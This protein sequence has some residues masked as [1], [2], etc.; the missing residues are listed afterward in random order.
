MWEIGSGSEVAPR[1]DLAGLKKWK[2]KVGKAM[3]ALRITV[4]E[5]LLEHI[6]YA[7]TPK[8]AWDTFAALFSKKSNARLQLLENK[9][10]SVEQKEMK[11]NQYFNKVKSLCQ[12]ILELDPTTSISESTMR[13]II[14]HGLSLEYKSFIN[15]VQDWP[16]QPSLMDLEK[17]ASQLRVL[18]KQMSMVSLK[19]NKNEGTLFSGKSRD[20]AK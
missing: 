18:A 19:N 1:E 12:E 2:I 20:R 14:I 13:R 4:E 17:F 6:R 15:V 10:L 16:V 7:E 5:E 11:I 9:L 3:F 8:V